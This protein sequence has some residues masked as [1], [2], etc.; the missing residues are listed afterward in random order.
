MPDSRDRHPGQHSDQAVVSRRR[1][2]ILGLALMLG[3][4]AG[5]VLAFL[6]DYL[7]GRVKTL[8]QA[9]AIV[10]PAGA[11][12]GSVDRRAGAGRVSPSA[13]AANSAAMIRRPQGCCRRRCSR[14]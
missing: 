10:G 9:E 1:M 2:L 7:D 5:I 3:L 13:G 14:P 4:G 11:C 12:R 8:E 6:A